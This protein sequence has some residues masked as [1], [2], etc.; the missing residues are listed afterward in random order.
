MVN[1]DRRTL[2]YVVGLAIGDGNLSNP[3]GRAARLRITCDTRYKLLIQNICQAIQTLLPQNRVNI[4]QR[5]TSFVDISCY[6]KQWEHW[7]GWQV[8]RGSKYQQ[9]VSVP[10]WI[11]ENEEFLIPCLKGLIETDG[12]IYYDRGY[13]MVNFITTIPRLAQAVLAMISKLGFEAHL[14]T[15]YGKSKTKYTVRVSKNVLTFINT[16]DLIKR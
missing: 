2:A 13:K 5:S 14:Y 12:S 15:F 6:S 4:I 10:E 8:G 16:L 11:R 1:T 9:N 7:L 3:N